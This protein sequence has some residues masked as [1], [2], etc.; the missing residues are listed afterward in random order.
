LFEVPE[1]RS[2]WDD[3]TDSIRTKADWHERSGE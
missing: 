2:S 1:I 3:F